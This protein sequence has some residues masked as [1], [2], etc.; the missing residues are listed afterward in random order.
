MTALEVNEVE[1]ETLKIAL[2]D[3]ID[4]HIE[5]LNDSD[6]EE[7]RLGFME[8]LMGIVEL[9]RKIEIKV[10]EKQV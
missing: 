1:L 9:Y 7:V 2:G 4:N 6:I 5:Y 10:K 3:S 8:H